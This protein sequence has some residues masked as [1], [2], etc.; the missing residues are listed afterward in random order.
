MAKLIFCHLIERR[1]EEAYK[2]IYDSIQLQPAI[3]IK[4]YPL[5]KSNVKRYLESNNPKYQPIL[6]KLFDNTKYISYK[7]FKF[8]LYNNFKELVHYCM[9]NKIDVIS[10]YL[11]KI[12]YNK[13]TTKSNFWIAQHFYHYLKKRKINIKLNII[14]NYADIQYLNDNEF[15]LIL[16]D[17]AY[18][19]L[20]LYS[21]LTSKLNYAKKKFN[22]YIII[23][24]ISNEAAKLLKSAKT[25]NNII[26]SPNNIIIKDFF[27]YLT[28]NEKKIM[29]TEMLMSNKYIIYFDHKLA[30]LVSTYTNV[31]SGK[32]INTNIIIPVITNCEHI[33]NIKDINEFSPKC[34]IPP[35][36]IDKDKYSNNIK[37]KSSSLSSSFVSLKTKSLNKYLP[38]NKKYKRKLNLV[39]YKDYINNIETKKAK[40]L[41]ENT[42]KPLNYIN[43]FILSQP[44]VPTKNYNIDIIKLNKYY[45]H[46]PS[47]IK[48]IVEKVI[49]NT[50]YISYQDFYIKFTANID[51][52]KQYL[53]EKNITTIKLIIFNIDSSNRWVSQHLYHYL[54]NINI[55]IINNTKYIKENDF[56]VYTDDYIR[57]DHI[58]KKFFNNKLPLY[59]L[60]IIG[61]YID[62]RI[63][64]KLK[65]LLTS[66]SSFI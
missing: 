51:K 58:I 48:T 61:L 17:C 49:K 43:N 39:H 32:I 16:D 60:Y 11:D 31:Y 4:S 33:N 38:I 26:L 66:K 25:N 18:S 40:I 15:I 36:K 6:K 34:P 12:D 54:K 8:V 3:P 27:S 7:T 5:N 52:L 47:R 53:I 50:V 13:I 64:N 2:N 45:S 57:N 65:S 21:V 19:G 37:D 28:S 10:L 56:I 63:N 35:Y 62:H 20:Q 22:I 46:L 29:L 30:D 14:Y 9:K 44:I 59:R 41:Y 55:I 23:T 1:M 42:N 24:F